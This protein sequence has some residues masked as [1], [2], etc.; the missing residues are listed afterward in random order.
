MGVHIFR[1]QFP[2]FSLAAQFGK[3][4]LSLV[5]LTDFPLEQHAVP[6]VPGPK[7]IVKMVELP[8]TCWC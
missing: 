1:N 7:T 5:N 6:N 3:F 4:S 8:K 2:G